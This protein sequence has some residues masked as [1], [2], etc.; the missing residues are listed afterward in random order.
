MEE[1]Y[2]EEEDPS[3]GVGDSYCFTC[4]NTG[5]IDCH[6]GGDVCICLNNGELPCPD[7]EL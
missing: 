3:D 7:C 6:C 2:F 1:D 4:N 5:T